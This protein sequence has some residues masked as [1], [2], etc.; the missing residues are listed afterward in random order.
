MEGYGKVYG[1]TREERTVL[2]NTADQIID[3]LFNA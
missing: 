3:E 1:L 2:K